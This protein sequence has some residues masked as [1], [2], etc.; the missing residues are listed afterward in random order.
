[1]SERALN[2]S[3]SRPSPA[4]APLSGRRDSTT[5]QVGHAPSV[6]TDTLSLGTAASPADPGISER[7]LAQ[8]KRLVEVA[9]RAAGRRRP[10]GYCYRAVHGYLMKSGS[11]D[12]VSGSIPWT[13]ARYARQFGEYLN[14]G[15]NAARLGLRKLD[16]TNPYEAPAGALVV[17]RPGA[18][19]TRPPRAGDIAVAA[20]NGKFYNDG[21]MN[22]GGPE[23]FPPGNRHVVG[24][25][26]PL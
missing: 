9:A 1:M 15:D 10:G 2:A 20:G 26:V 24:I 23:G 25:Y 8:I 16:L 11:G 6:P 17:V 22:Y 19:G 5:A 7:G 18:P 14:K 4:L 13:H 21:L 12:L 3:S